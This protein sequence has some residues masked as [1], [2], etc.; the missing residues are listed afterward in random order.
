MAVENVFKK[1]SATE[2][3]NGGGASADDL[4]GGAASTKK[5]S[6]LNANMTD[7][8]SKSLQSM[9]S[10]MSGK[11]QTLLGSDLAKNLKLDNLASMVQSAMKGGTPLL[12]ALQKSL[13]SII[14]SHLSSLIN[15]SSDTFAFLQKMGAAF[16]NNIIDKIV[17]VLVSKLVLPE[18]VYLAGLKAIKPIKSNIKYRNNYIRKL[19]IKKDLVKVLEFV[20]GEIGMRYTNENSKGVNDGITAARYGSYRVAKYIMTQLNLEL[21]EL[22]NI[23][24]KIKGEK[25]DAQTILLK[26]FES[27]IKTLENTLAGTTNET[28]KATI[29]LSI[30]KIKNSINQLDIIKEREFEKEAEYKGVTKLIDKGTKNLYSICKNIIVSSFSRL[31]VKE[32]NDIIIKFNIHP[33]AFGSNDKEFGK[34][35]LITQSD[36][37]RLAPFARPKNSVIEEAKAI[38]STVLVPNKITVKF[39]SP[40]NNNI[41]KIYIYLQSKELHGEFYMLNKSFYERM[42]YPVYSTLI[43]SLDSAASGFFKAGLGKRYVDTI[44]AIESA[45]YDYTISVEDLLYDPAK[46]KFVSINDLTPIPPPIEDTAGK[47]KKSPGNSTKI[48]T[49]PAYGPTIVN[50]IKPSDMDSL[51]PGATTTTNPNGNPNSNPTY[52]PTIDNKIKPS[53]MDSLKPGATTTE[54]GIPIYV[55]DGA[56]PAGLD[57]N[58]NYIYGYPSETLIN[59]SIVNGNVGDPTPA[60]PNGNPVSDDGTPNPIIGYDVNGNAIYGKS[61]TAN[62][63]GNPNGN[64]SATTTENGIPIYVI[65]GAVPVGS[66]S[67]GKPIYGYPS[68]TLIKESIVNGNVGEPTAANPNGNPVSD[69]GSPNPIIGYDVNGNA[70]YGK[71]I[72]YPSSSPIGLD[73]NN[74]PIFGFIIVDGISKPIIG[75]NSSGEPIFGII[76]TEDIFTD[77]KGELFY[78]YTEIGEKIVGFTD[79]GKSITKYNSDNSYEVGGRK[80]NIIGFDFDN[81]PVFGYTKNG[82]AIYAFDKNKKPV[83]KNASGELISSQHSLLRVIGLSINSYPIY[84]Y[85]IKGIPVMGFD[86]LG[87]ETIALTDEGYPILSYDESGNPLLGTPL[88]TE[89]L[90]NISAKIEIIKLNVEDETL[91]DALDKLEN[92]EKDKGDIDV[93]IDMIKTISEIKKEIQPNYKE[94]FIIGYNSSGFF[95]K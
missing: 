88:V 37:N 32:L 60:N 89:I 54:N 78:G 58:G 65:D 8:L 11:L 10:A 26:N 56:V 25:L 51:K 76:K 33:S 94:D 59:E 84:T 24:P 91:R 63:N 83:I 93:D 67:N 1:M 44:Y 90:K 86:R 19:A 45:Y 73:Q 62:P 27:Q 18:E 72:Y 36:V 38:K 21:S 28:I 75:Y 40:R 48:Q 69:N 43:D 85:N 79:D 66:D 53:D 30:D 2:D 61:T 31:T 70:I 34:E 49:N 7:S 82:E 52:G 17:G 22:K 57:S 35:F 92:S 64:P 16:Q 42:K 14:S 4:G 68:E 87:S 39:I 6:A 55:I 23:Y 29:V 50:K 20:D 9:T 12:G 80:L 5:S 71:P 3:Q 77:E 47:I 74:N 13:N 95:I 15:D 46:E 41:K 81:T